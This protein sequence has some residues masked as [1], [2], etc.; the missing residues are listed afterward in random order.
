M[1]IQEILREYLPETAT[2]PE[3]RCDLPEL[4]Y[5][6]GLNAA[7]ELV[8]GAIEQ[9]FGERVAFYFR[10]DRITYAELQQQVN[11][12]GNAFKALGVQPGDRALLRL[13]DRP[14]LVYCI[15]ALQK[16]GAVPVPTYTLSRAQDLVYREN[17]T[18]A[19]VVVS[20][21]GLLDE[22]EKAR[23]GFRFVESLVAVPSTKQPGYSSYE[24]L[25]EGAPTVLAAAA[26]ACEDPALILYTSG[27]TGEPKGC[28]HTHADTLAIAD[29]YA[30]YCVQPTPEDVFAGPPPIPFALGFGFFLVFPLRFGAAAV[31]ADQKTPGVML[32]AM[33]RYG[34]TVF[35]AVATYYGM[36]LEQLVSEGAECFAGN[37]RLLLCGGEPLA[38]R[39]A[40][41][42]ER[43]FGLPLLQFLGTTE[44]LHNIVSYRADEMPRSG[45]FGHAVPGYEVAVRDPGTFVELPR[46]EPGLLTVRGPTG[47]KYW[48]KPEQQKKTVREGWN[49]VKDI[50]R[51]DEDGYLYYVARSDEM[52]VSAGYNIAPADVENVLL[53]H[54]AVLKAACI[55]APDP[56]G[57]RSKVVKACVVL[58]SGYE[59]SDAL[60]KEL[61]EFFKANA[62]PFMYPR[63]VEF[64]PEL[65][66][67]LTGKI[68]RSELLMRELASPRGSDD[69]V[70]TGGA[71]S[72]GTI[73]AS[74][75]HR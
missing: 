58:R 6:P 57:R 69:A 51:M 66:E 70:E 55:G 46:G 54:P 52:I 11:R 47:T 67:T 38:A 74:G 30:R 3:Q 23:P 14:E 63:L 1:S 35:A 64:L 19:K 41:G 13:P 27:S 29:S 44:M 17:D 65:P 20:D 68:R 26:T 4:R 36:L 12:V 24:D 59:S 28:L 7:E 9:G 21:A 31:L 15:L 50:V 16:I 2:L 43:A 71:E 56:E 34:V 45:S 48:R 40:G 60:V 75:S 49:I 53:R 10:D 33:E 73:R 8:D 72:D 5:P 62:P 39:V 18:G 25:V 32:K 42:C 37:L 61:Q 22:L